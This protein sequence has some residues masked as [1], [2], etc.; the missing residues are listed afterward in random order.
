MAATRYGHNEGTTRGRS[1]RPEVPSRRR[2]GGTLWRPTLPRSRLP[3]SRQAASPA[4]GTH[5]TGPLSSRLFVPPWSSE[6]DGC[7]DGR[8]VGAARVTTC[9]LR[10]SPLGPPSPHAYGPSPARHA[11]N[12]CV[13]PH[14]SGSH[15]SGSNIGWRLTRLAEPEPEGRARRY[16][17]QAIRPAVPWRSSRG[18]RA[19]DRGTARNCRR[20]QALWA[21]WS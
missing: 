11:L 21:A 15:A 1:L 16:T 20:C 7:G 6:T 9:S 5:E 12:P 2:Y 4:S 10:R 14:R 17:N 13:V 8:P 18:I 19:G 3:A